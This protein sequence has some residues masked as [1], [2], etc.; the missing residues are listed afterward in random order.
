M[1]DVRW[2]KQEEI[3]YYKDRCWWCESSSGK[4][5]VAVRLRELQRQY[6][7]GTPNERLS[8]MEEFMGVFKEHCKYPKE[9]D[10]DGKRYKTDFTTL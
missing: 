1:N 9:I 4:G 3:K 7:K 8:T 6:V 10:T 5:K 2:M